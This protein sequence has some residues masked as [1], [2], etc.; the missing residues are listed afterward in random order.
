MSAEEDR[1][2]L[3][4]LEYFFPSSL[5][6]IV[7]LECKIVEESRSHS[8]G[9]VDSDVELLLEEENVETSAHQSHS[10]EEV[11]TDVEVLPEE[12]TLRT[13]AHR[14]T[15]STHRLPEGWRGEGVVRKG[16]RCAGRCDVYIY[17]PGGTKFRSRTELKRYCVKKKIN[18]GVDLFALV[19]NQP[20]SRPWE[21][22]EIPN[23]ECQP[24]KRKRG[25]PPKIR[26]P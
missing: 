8:P 6:E 11:T 2:C 16:G 14:D 5:L 13:P 12:K 26:H 24:P 19:Q 21:K 3:I 9:D 7:E 25:R 4:D 17:S 15:S 10:L 1:L 23:E 22:D 20:A 18:F